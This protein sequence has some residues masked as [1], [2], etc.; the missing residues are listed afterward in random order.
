MAAHGT[1]ALLAVAVAL[2]TTVVAALL[3]PACSLG[4]L[5]LSNA[6]RA[7]DEGPDTALQ[8]DLAVRRAT[9][10]AEIAVLQR[11]VAALPACQRV[12]AAAPQ[13]AVPEPPAAPPAEPPPTSAPPSVR[14]PRPEPP[15]GLDE[16]RWRDRDLTMLKGCWSLDSSYTMVDGRTGRPR[17][18]RSW[19]MCF[20]SQ[21]RGQET[22]IFTDGARC[23][24][25]ITAQFQ[26]NGRLRVDENTDVP[27]GDGSRITRRRTTC[28]IAAG[29]R[30][31]CQNMH[32]AHPSLPP[33]NVTLRR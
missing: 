2:V 24:G 19:Q 7:L 28:Q 20:D 22:Q 17:G 5:T 23:A 25:P 16:E 27:C 4:G 18:V 12:D 10:E 14:P 1:L 11:R 29:G 31:Q 30:A 3:L 15:R 13:F 9:L 26:A 6:C 21:G 32:P 8:D 33:S